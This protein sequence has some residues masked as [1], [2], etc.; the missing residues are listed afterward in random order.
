MTPMRMSLCMLERLRGALLKRRSSWSE[1]G[2][3]LNCA[4]STTDSSNKTLLNH[5]MTLSKK[6]QNIYLSSARGWKNRIRRNYWRFKS[7]YSQSSIGPS[8]VVQPTP[9]TTREA[10]ALLLMNKRGLTEARNWR[11]LT[12]KG[13]VS[14]KIST[15]AQ[16]AVARGGKSESKWAIIRALAHL[17]DDSPSVIIRAGK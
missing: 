12:V 10:P 5:P 17:N 7:N 9:K 11:K 15:L 13:S 3:T 8:A 4:T 16:L 6:A 14:S 2:T 1:C